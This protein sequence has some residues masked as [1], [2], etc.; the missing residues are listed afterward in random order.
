[1]ALTTIEQVR[2]LT[3]ISVDE[4]S[5][6]DLNSLINQ[7]TKEIMSKINVNVNREHIQYIDNTR[8]NKIDGSNTTYY[9]KNWEN[10]Y[11]SDRNADGLVDTND[12]IVYAVASDGTETKATISSV[13]Y[14]DGSFTLDSPYDSSYNLYVTYAYSHFDPVTPDP[15]LELAATYLV[16]SYAYLKRD[17][18]LDGS[19]KFGNV[20]INEKLSASYGEFYKR[21]LEILKQLNKKSALSSNWVESK[22]KI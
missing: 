8:E 6:E 17:V 19:V 2:L 20:S 14:D 3:N 18:G 21:Y 5:D 9:V 15:L 4:I 11:I 7:A 13:D 22:V 16:A 1:M 12:I 10:K